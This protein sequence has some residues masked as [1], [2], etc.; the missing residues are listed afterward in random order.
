MFKK[1][2]YNNYIMDNIINRVLYYCNS[3]S[4]LKLHP[5]E[6]IMQ[7]SIDS[8]LFLSD[9]SLDDFKIRVS[10]S[11]QKMYEDYR[12]DYDKANKNLNPE[13]KTN[14]I[15]LSFD[16]NVKYESVEDIK[17]ELQE[18]LEKNFDEIII[19]PTSTKIH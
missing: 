19:T 13:N 12:Q 17:K 11:I 14:D 6:L 9:C 5:A 15:E 16:K 8:L 18:V 10:N 3:T 2:D 1:E 4:E 7:L